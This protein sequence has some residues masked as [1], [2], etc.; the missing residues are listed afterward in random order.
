MIYKR[1]IFNE[2]E[3]HSRDYNDS[4]FEACKFSGITFK[5][6]NFVNCIFKSC[7]FSES[8][9]DLV[10]FSKCKFPGTKLSF[11]D[12]SNTSLMDRNFEQGV[13]KACIFQK[14]K[15]GSKTDRKN[16]D[17]RTCNF[18]NTDLEGTAFVFCNLEKVNFIDSNLTNVIF[19]RCNLADADMSGANLTSTGFENSKTKNTLLD[20][21]GFVSI[22]ASRGFVLK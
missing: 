20:I 1:K 5:F 19:D 2:K 17:I 6:S 15:A 11:L 7:D 4:I 9:L 8:Y 12:F 14:L 18:S 21:N 10:S 22:G 13:M 16:Y 3:V